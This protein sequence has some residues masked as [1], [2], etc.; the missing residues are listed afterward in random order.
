[1][2]VYRYSNGGS[3]Q[4]DPPKGYKYN[5]AGNLVPI[6]FEEF[7]EEAVIDLGDLMRGV[8]N[9]ESSGGKLMVNPYSSATGLYGQ[10][11]N[12][13]K[14]LPFMKGVSRDQFAKDKDLQN[15]VFMMRYEGEL[16]NIPSLEK[17]AYDLTEEYAEQLGDK[18]DFTLD[19]VAALSN[20]L[21]R[22]GARQFFAALRDGR[23]YKPQGV[24]K[25]VME[26]LDIYRQGRDADQ[27]K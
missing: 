1:M 4:K 7:H 9:V 18:F 15:R 10:L 23:D 12:E 20:F 16:P 17:N 8:A 6:D 11:Y 13:I 27:E 5:E 3:L 25:P 22:Q 2:K 21:G 14:D 26:Y 24:N 19:E